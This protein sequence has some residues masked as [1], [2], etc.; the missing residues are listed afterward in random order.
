MN[1]LAW[2]GWRLAWG[3]W[4]GDAGWAMRASPARSPGVAEPGGALTPRGRCPLRRVAGERRLVRAVRVV[5][6]ARRERPHRRL[7]LHL[8]VVL[9]VVHLEHRLGGLGDPPDHDRPDLDRVPPGVVHLELGGL[10][11]PGPERNP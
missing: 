1:P 6:I 7:A 10:E 3:G 9:V 5:G 4:G 8:D 2:W 11:V